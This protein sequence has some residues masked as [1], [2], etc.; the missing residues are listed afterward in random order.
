MT[1]A[2][3]EANVLEWGINGVFWASPKLAVADI[4]GMPASQHVSGA[5]LLG[6]RRLPV[7]R[8]RVLGR[9]V[10]VDRRAK[11]VRYVVDDGTSSLPIIVWRKQDEDDAPLPQQRQHHQKA[12]TTRAAFR[13]SSNDST[14]KAHGGG[15]RIGSVDAATAAVGGDWLAAATPAVG[16]G[17]DKR[18][19]LFF[20]LGDLVTAMG[21]ISEFREQRQ[22][23]AHIAWAINDDPDAESVFWLEVERAWMDVYGSLR[24]RKGE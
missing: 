17:Q 24:Q 18:S 13:S 12:S 8:A 10:G 11:F 9:V 20:Q 4:L 15:S 14:S 7:Q 22:I 2:A 3:S 5:F 16:Y 21:T 23:T 1:T 6:P 19:C